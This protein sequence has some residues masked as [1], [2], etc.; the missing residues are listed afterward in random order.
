MPPGAGGQ[1][2]L[3]L[4]SPGCCCSNISYSTW[5]L[6]YFIKLGLPFAAFY[7]LNFNCI[8]LQDCGPQN[9]V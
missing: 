6:G 5:I 3:L 2:S 7:I 8:S 4:P 1:G 9:T